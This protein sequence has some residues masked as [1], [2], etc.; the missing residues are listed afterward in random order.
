MTSDFPSHSRWAAVEGRDPTSRSALVTGGGSGIGKACAAA[1][2]A[3]VVGVH[4]VD[5]DTEPAAAVAAGIG[6]E[7][8]VAGLADQAA[9]DGLPTGIGILVNNAGTQ[10]IAPLIEFPPERFALIQQVMVTAPLLL[11]RHSLPHMYTQGRGR[12][13]DVS[14][15]HGLRAGAFKAACVAAEHTL[16]GLSEVAAIEGAARGGTSN[17]LHPGHVRAVGREPDPRSGRRTWHQHRGRPERP[18]S[19]PL[20]QAPPENGRSR[21]GRNV[22]VLGPRELHHRCLAAPGRRLGSRLPRP[23]LHFQSPVRT[24]EAGD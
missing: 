6:G 9:I 23:A 11:M 24:R 2:A 12:I 5:R 3:A 21:S 14:S 1:P 13:V 10:H 17:C 4:V 18:T 15:V 8:H 7:A 16:E 22:V 20:R 19:D